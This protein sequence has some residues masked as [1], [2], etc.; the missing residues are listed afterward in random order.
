MRVDR[1]GFLGAAGSCLAAAAWPGLARG[2]DDDKSRTRL[3]LLGTKGGPSRTPT[4]VDRHL[5]SQVLLIR[6]VPYVVDCGLGVT[7]QLVRAGVP[8]RSLRHIFITHHHSDHNLEYGNLF[9]T[10]W[11][12][13]LTT[14]V[15]AWGPPPLVE[16]TR[17]FFALNGTD[18]DIRISDEGRADPRPL[19]RPHEFSSGGVVLQNED[20]KVTAAV[21]PH[22]PVTPS[23]AYRFD[24][25]DRSIVISGDTAYSDAVVA[26]AKGADVLVHEAM[27]LPA[28]ERLAQRVGNGS[29]LLEHL[30]AAHTTTEDVGRVAAAAGV[31]LLVVS[32][33]VPGDDPAITDEMW[34]AGARQHYQGRIVV[35]R[36]LQEI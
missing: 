19:L 7:D 29:R 2:A 23:F 5:P 16:M 33:L 8:L 15:D 3:I 32:H 17:Q 10:A 35:G 1:R 12:T 9:Y 26:L 27:Y 22:P 20:V 11:A 25:V 34:S 21:V 13:G 14:A 24:T 30:R 36:D 4:A 28:I 18:I 31:K 6:G